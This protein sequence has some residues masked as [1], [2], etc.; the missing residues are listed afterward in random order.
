MSFVGNTFVL[1]L[2]SFLGTKGFIIG[3]ISGHSII[4]CVKGERSFSLNTLNGL[5]AS[6][7]Y[8]DRLQC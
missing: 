6:A 8:A 7:I 1:K 3:G 5:N 4:A 2:T